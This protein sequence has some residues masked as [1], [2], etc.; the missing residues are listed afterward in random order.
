LYWTRRIK[1]GFNSHRPRIEDDEE[2]E[3]EYIVE[4][5]ESEDFSLD[6]IDDELEDNYDSDEIVDCAVNRRDQYNLFIGLGEINLTRSM[7]DT[8]NFA[9]TDYSLYEPRVS[10]DGPLAEYQTFKSKE[11]F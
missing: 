3:D 2:E 6:D 11:H 7:H 5:G 4:Q 8:T 9:P 1:L 10:A